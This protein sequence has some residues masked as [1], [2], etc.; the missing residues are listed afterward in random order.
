[1]RRTQTLPLRLGLLFA[2]GAGLIGCSGSNEGRPRGGPPPVSVSVPLEREVTDYQD[3]TGRTE[4][5]DSVQVRARVTGYLDKI[6]FQEGGEVR[7]GEVLYE[8]DPRPYVA[9]LDQDKADLV[10]KQATVVQKEALYKRTASLLP[11]RASSR[12]EYDVVKGD[13]EVAR[14]GVGQAEAKVRLSELNVDW[15]RVTSPIN[16]RV[17]RTLITRGNLVVADNTVLTTVVSMDPMYAYFDVD[18]QTVLLVKELI[19]EGKVRSARDK[20]QDGALTAASALGVLGCPA[21]E[22]PLLAAASLYPGKQ[23]LLI[24]VSLRLANEKDYTHQG[25]LDFVNNRLDPSTGTLQIRGIFP[26]PKPPVGDRLLS[27]GMF[28]RVR[29]TIGAPHKALLVSERALGADQGLR[30]VFVVDA[31]DKVVRREVKVGQQWDGLREITS[32]LQPKERIIVSGVQRVQ[33]GVV[34]RPRLVDMPTMPTRR[35][36]DKET[37]RQGDKDAKKPAQQV[38]PAG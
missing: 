24:P 3:V 36:G 25:S 12:E 31:G 7:Q 38:R 23:Y 13:Y 1:M 15:T 28:V 11:S 17:S 33:P 6:N 19:R 16:G 27:P 35:Q 8:I 37:G 4:A 34:V 32:G 5:I 29:V 30:F 10:N 22:S 18:E 21:G 26:N 20:W 9:Q 2:A 14:A